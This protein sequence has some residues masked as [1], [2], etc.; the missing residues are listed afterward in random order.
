MADGSYA[1][2][3]EVKSFDSNFL[4]LSTSLLYFVA[5]PDRDLCKLQRAITKIA[6]FV[7]Y[8]LKVDAITETQHFRSSVVL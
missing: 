3:E 1:E 4:L 6:G 7:P 5:I 8:F 2:G